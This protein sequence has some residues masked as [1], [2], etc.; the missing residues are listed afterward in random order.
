MHDTSDSGP[1]PDTDTDV[2]RVKATLHFN[3][4]LALLK[5]VCTLLAAMPAHDPSISEEFHTVSRNSGFDSLPPSTSAPE[6]DSVK[7]IDDADV[8]GGKDEVEDVDWTAIPEADFWGTYIT[9]IVQD[10]KT[11]AKK[12]NR[13]ECA[14]HVAALELRTRALGPAALRLSGRLNCGRKTTK[15]GT[16]H[17]HDTH[18]ID[19]ENVWVQVACA[20]LCAIAGM[21]YMSNLA[22]FLPDT[23][24]AAATPASCM[25]DMYSLD[26]K[27]V[28]AEACTEA[29]PVARLVHA[30]VFGGPV[31]LL[32]SKSAALLDS[33]LLSIREAHGETIA[34]TMRGAVEA[35]GE[36]MPGVSLDLV[37]PSNPGLGAGIKQLVDDFEALAD[38]VHIEGIAEEM[39]LMMR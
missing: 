24:A 16:T 10:A 32:T 15:T 9:A 26:R 30:R 37:V 5:D 6:D 23:A 8:D 34:A 14:L 1:D 35:A 18:D 39:Y 12:F 17:T 21:P 20:H 7:V 29:N 22:D 38:A 25:K 3:Y 33:L 4:T 19:P 13:P 31:P 28:E 2:D 27:D 11:V 36:A